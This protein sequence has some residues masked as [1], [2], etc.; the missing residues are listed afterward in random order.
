MV[1]IKLTNYLQLNKLLYAHQYGFQRGFSTEQNLIHVTNF[2][3]NALNNGNYC[4]GIFLDLR[5]AFDTVSHS[6]LL[7]KLSK[8]GVNGTALKWFRCYLSQRS[9]RVEVNGCLSKSALI[10]CGV[11]QG[12]ILGPLLFLCYINDLHHSTELAT[13]LFADDTSCL[14]EN[15]NLETLIA[16]VNSEL[17]KLALWFKANKMAVN[18]NKTNYIIFHTRGKK[19]DPN[20]PDVVF[21]SNEP[22]VSHSDP[23]LINKLERIHDNHAVDKMRSFKLL[24]VFLDEHLS[25]SNH[26]THVCAK[27]SRSNFCLRR[28]ANFA[29]L[30]ILN[31]FA[32]TRRKTVTHFRRFFTVLEY[33]PI[34]VK[35]PPIT[36]PRTLYTVKKKNLENFKNFFS[37]ESLNVPN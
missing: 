29:P 11:F 15:K 7:T 9:Q 4:I 12:S 22:G 26:I 25:F 14:A 20:H 1:A 24:G 27:L 18:V 32:P 28:V 35:F 19:I 8:L 33:S 10:D 17:Q 2:I 31:P 37:Y 21:N 30:N 23:S 5:K 36:A 3:G 34:G 16:H 13:F 6:I